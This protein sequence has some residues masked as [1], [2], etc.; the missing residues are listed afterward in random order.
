MA[1]IKIEKKKPIWPWILIIVLIILALLYFF[2]FADNDADDDFSDT[3]DMEQVE[4][5][6]SLEIEGKRENTDTWENEQ[7]NDSLSGGF[8]SLSSAYYDAIE[9]DDKLGKDSTYTNNALLKLVDAVNAK[10]MEHD[11]DLDSNL[12]QM[13]KNAMNT[14]ENAKSISSEKIKNTGDKVMKALEELQKKEYPQLSEQIEEAKKSLS[15]IKTNEEMSNQQD[16]IEAFFNKTA[17]V[18]RNMN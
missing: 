14:S 9:E 5:R 2:V 6:D 7:L 13:R 10:A 1:E 16:K 11:I 15:E 17:D 18:L 4:T 3:D 12:D 8:A